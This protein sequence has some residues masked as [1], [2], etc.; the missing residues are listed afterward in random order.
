MANVLL[1]IAL[2]VPVVLFWLL[3]TRSRLNGWVAAAIS[4][5]AGWALNYA[6]ASVAHESTDIAAR[7]GWIR[8]TVLVALTWL[9]L[10]FMRRRAARALTVHSSRRLAARLDSSVGGTHIRIASARKRSPGRSL[11][12]DR[13]SAPIPR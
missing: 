10:F 8:P 4:I 13:S 1:V 6:W 5:A 9:V 12:S 7:F 3:K 11:P 2:G